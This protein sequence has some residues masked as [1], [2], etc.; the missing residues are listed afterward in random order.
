MEESDSDNDEP[1]PRRPDLSTITAAAAAAPTDEGEKYP[2]EG[3]YINIAEK[4]EIMRMREVERETILAERRDEAQRYKQNRLLRQLVSAQEEKEKEQQRRKRSADEAD[5]DD[6][7]RK[8]S[9][10]RAKVA[11]SSTATSSG[12][13]TLRRQRAEKNDRLRRREEDREREKEKGTPRKG[14]SR[15]QDAYGDEED[16]WNRQKSPEPEKR[17]RPDAELADFQRLRIGRA[18][19]PE[20]Y[21]KPSFE[22]VIVD[23]YVRVLGKP[24]PGQLQKYHMLPIKGTSALPPGA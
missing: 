17:G 13:D 3:L 19:F 1:Q 4:E 5:I 22:K 11:E 14:G 21:F 2:V 24:V 15:L 9:R 12:I 18:N 7:G 16:E 23:C 10:Q 8:P 20:I 6:E